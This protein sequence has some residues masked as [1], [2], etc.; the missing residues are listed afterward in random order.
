M[1]IGIEKHGYASSCL[2]NLAFME[3]VGHMVVAYYLDSEGFDFT[4]IYKN[5]TLS[6]AV[7]VI[8]LKLKTR[9]RDGNQV[10]S[11]AGRSG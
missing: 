2:S 3:D 9:G 5:L 4:T 6:L 8:V 7:I 11:G 1:T 10:E